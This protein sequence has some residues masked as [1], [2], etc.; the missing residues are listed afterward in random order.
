MMNIRELTTIYPEGT[1]S[2]HPIK[3]TTILSLPVDTTA[4]FSIK[5]ERLTPTEIQVLQNLFPN[6]SVDDDLKKHSWY[7]YLY[8]NVPIIDDHRSYRIIH[9]KLKNE[10]PHK[11]D[12]LTHF[13]QLFHGM[14]DAFFI[15]ETSGILI[16]SHSSLTYYTHYIEDM[17]LTLEE[18]FQI[19]AHVY[20]GNFNPLSPNFIA[21]FK[22][23]QRIVSHYTK[24]QYRVFSFLDISLD[25]LTHQAISQSPIMQDLKHLLQGD[26]EFG[27][28]IK[29]LWQEQ[30][31]LTSTSKKL[32]IHRN[33]LQYK[34]DKF[35]ERTG[36]ALKNMN[37]LA[38]CYL[39]TL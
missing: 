7:Q 37:D 39:A 9:F 23:E 26:E 28:I 16:E 21:Q 10:S 31:N 15:N 4:W 14:E 17:L 36:Y 3:D 20:L 30:G 33:T 18:D 6:T 38:L 8:C 11:R 13:S 2:N 19:R 34:L 12:W 22:E 29:T 35:S 27:D 25:Y 5:K 24:Q 32:F 1:L